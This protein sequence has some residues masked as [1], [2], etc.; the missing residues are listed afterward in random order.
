[1]GYDSRVSEHRYIPRPALA[2]LPIVV[3]V[4]SL[5][6]RGDGHEHWSWMHLT[7]LAAPLIAAQ[8]VITVLFY[9]RIVLT[10]AAIEIHGWFMMRRQLGW[11]AVR[12]L[13]YKGGGFNNGRQTDKIILRGSGGKI[14]ATSAHRGFEAMKRRIEE[15]LTAVGG[16]KLAE[17]IAAVENSKWSWV[18]IPH[19][20][21]F[22][23]SLITLML[24][25]GGFYL[26]FQLPHT[27]FFAALPVN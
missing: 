16:P 4:G 19:I 22:L 8:L 12:T 5:L 7:M 23:E 25:A 21:D 20:E 27:S 17:A 14:V 6:I 18:Y 10:P 11:D 26:T 24:I 3:V 2:W 9:Q 13:R 1:M 15:A